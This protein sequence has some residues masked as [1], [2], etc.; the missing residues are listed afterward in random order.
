[1]KSHSFIHAI[2]VLVL[3]LSSAAVTA[4][5]PTGSAARKSPFVGRWTAIDPYDASEIRLSIG[6][7][8]PG[9]FRITWT[10]SYF[11]FCGGEA[12]IARGTGRLNEGIP[13]LLKASLH[14]ECPTTGNKTD[15]EVI[16]SY[17][18]ATDTIAWTDGNGV[19]TTWHRFSL[20]TAARRE[21]SLTVIALPND[22]CNYG[23][24]IQGFTETFGIPVNSVAPGAS[25]ADELQAI[26]D[27]IDN[28]G[29][30]TPD[31][32]DVGPGFA[33]EAQ[34]DGLITPYKVSAW[35]TIPDFM[36]DGSG[37]WYG[38]YYGVMAL[39]TNTTVSSVP[40]SWQD[41]LSNPAVG[42]V[43]LG[44]EPTV[45][46]LGFFAVYGAALANSGSLDDIGPGVEFFRALR[47][48]GILIDGIGNGDTLA[49]GETP[50]LPEWSYLALAQRYANPDSQ[51]EVIVPADGAIASFYAQAISA[52]APHPNAARLWM[53]YLYSDVG[54]LAW[55]EGY[56]FPARFEH[57][58]DRGA[59]PQ[60]LLDRLPD[61]AGALFPSLEQ[62]EAAKAFVEAN[63]P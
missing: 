44:G 51:I 46:N 15:F 3:V 26:R 11:S 25:S 20:I 19:T 63:W 33:V 8:L 7:P 31:V 13:H 50:V 55:L 18:L 62:T 29:Q 53:E 61:L 4:L 52:Y 57:M 38:D 41:L 12:G 43:A 2:V 59:I 54:Q 10:E 45:S 27:G 37:Y 9:P 1:M 16:W 28:P 24:L 58:R 42:Q 17:D 49:S 23:A 56:C 21:G 14:L 34:S 40:T 22:W 35:V 60:E 47:A 48:A 30:D 5:T 32:I 36:K 39:A 6:G